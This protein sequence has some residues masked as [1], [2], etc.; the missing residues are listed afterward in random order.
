MILP[1]RWFYLPLTL[2]CPCP[3]FALTLPWWPFLDLSLTLFW[4]CPDLTSTLPR[5]GLSLALTL[6]WQLA[7]MLKIVPG[8]YFQSLVKIG[9][10]T[11]E[12]FLI[13][14]NVSRTNVAWTNVVLAVENVQYGPRNLPFKFGQS[15]ASNSWDIADIEFLVG[16]WVVVGFK[17]YCVYN[18]NIW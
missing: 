14:T 7:Y 5:P 8:T 2:F 16:R 1:W 11:A 15:R 12:I 17:A 6:P 3:K 9:S 13:W 4:S 10:V 18:E